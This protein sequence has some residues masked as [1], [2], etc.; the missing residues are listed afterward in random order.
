AMDLREDLYMKLAG[1]HDT[2]KRRL[3]E[4][5]DKLT[6]EDAVQYSK[7][8]FSRA[9][10]EHVLRRDTL[11]PAMVFRVG[12]HTEDLPISM[13]LA[14][15]RD[16]DGKA[17]TE[18]YY[19]VPYESLHFESTSNGYQAELTGQVSIFDDNYILI[20]G[21][22]IH[23]NCFAPTKEVM[24]YGTIINQKNF[25]LVPDNYHL[26]LSLEDTTGHRLGVLRSDFTVNELPETSLGI[27][28]IQLSSN[29]KPT[30]QSSQFEKNGY[31]I[32][33]LPSHTINKK[34]P[35]YVYF[36]IY[37]LTRNESGD[38]NFQIDYRIRAQQKK[39]GFFHKLIGGKDARKP[40]ISLSENRSSRSREQIEHV[41]LDLNKINSERVEL[42]VMVTDLN[43]PK[44]VSSVVTFKLKG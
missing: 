3:Y 10:K 36:E 5:S 18:I 34:N 28:D 24:N 21:N 15:F 44:Q 39:R 42:E 2:F 8:T 14:S 4:L 7:T 30:N 9:D 1:Q 12:A 35:L 13:S 23:E 43:T 33:P 40:I 16:R 19:G 27:S 31:F 6:A 25:T 22:Y 20:A 37:N 11:A 38:T 17:R 26:V 32:V 41:A 29:I